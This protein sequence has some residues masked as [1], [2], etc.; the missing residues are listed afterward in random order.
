MPPP[1]S[2]KGEEARTSSKTGVPSPSYAPLDKQQP[3][4][5]RVRPFPVRCDSLQGFQSL[6]G[7]DGDK[8]GIPSPGRTEK[9]LVMPYDVSLGISP[10]SSPTRES[11]RADYFSGRRAGGD[12]RVRGAAKGADRIQSEEDLKL[13]FCSGGEGKGRE[14]IADVKTGRFPVTLDCVTSGSG[15]GRFCVREELGKKD[16]KEDENEYRQVRS[17]AEAREQSE[18][19]AVISIRIRPEGG[20]L[21]MTVR[22]GRERKRRLGSKQNDEDVWEQRRETERLQGEMEDGESER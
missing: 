6:R 16:E 11:G 5:A 19:N 20:G 17:E 15:S 12:T 7:H 13:V 22:Y 14:R 10:Y 9:G 8:S 4:H 3:R 18:E 21:V 1:T 2:E